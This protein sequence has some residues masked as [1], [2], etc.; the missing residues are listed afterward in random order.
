MILSSR[1]GGF[2]PGPSTDPDLQISSIRL[3]GSWVRHRSL[4]TFV[5]FR[6]F[7]QRVLGVF[8][9]RETM[10]RHP[11]P[12]TESLGLV[13]RLRRY[14]GML[15]LLHALLGGLCCLDRRYPLH[16]KRGGLSGSWAVLAN[17]LRSKTPA[18]PPSRPLWPGGCCLPHTRTASAPHSGLSGLNRAARALPVYAS[19][20]RS[21]GRMQHSVAGRWS[22]DRLLG[23][24]E[25]FD[26]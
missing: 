18:D 2:P 10:L 11:L 21:L 8:P 6:R 3:F 26:V 5:A 17:V 1:P 7:Q 22:A 12:S 25:G 14:Y 9:S 24:Y 4:S 16:W 15:R 13:P 23:Y 20:G 19:P